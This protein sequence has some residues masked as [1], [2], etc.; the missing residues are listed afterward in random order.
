MIRACIEAQSLRYYIEEAQNQNKYFFQLKARELI[1]REKEDMVAAAQANL[2]FQ[3]LNMTREEILTKYP[4]V[5]IRTEDLEN[6]N[7]AQEGEAAN[8]ESERDSL[9]LSYLNNEAYKGDDKSQMDEN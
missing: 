6:G 8:H 9:K 7:K 1:E 3:K 5:K 2:L 4:E